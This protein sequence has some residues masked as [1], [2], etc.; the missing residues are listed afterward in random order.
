VGSRLQRAAATITG[1]MI[2]S[3]VLGIGIAAA[4]TTPTTVPTTTPITTATTPTTVAPTTVAPTTVPV[5]TTTAKEKSADKE[6]GDD[7]PWLEV[8][9]GAV[10]VGAIGAG[11]MALLG[12]RNRARRVVLDW[13]RRA[14]D[15][16]TEIGAT[17]RL[18]AAGT[19][20]SAAI[21]Q[22]VV[23]SL[24]ALDDLAQSAPDEMSR[25]TV[26]EARQ[27]VRALGIAI[28]ADVS[29]RRAQPP[30]PPGQLEAAAAGLRETAAE[31]D[32]T[33]RSTYHVFNPPS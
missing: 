27:A 19:P 7:F 18:L 3:L 21:A 5:T 20:V 2:T 23:A 1:G 8:L 4:Q 15:A 31:T 29:A 11:V 26:H 17:A 33:L 10:I 9:I 12:K 22:Q 13:R 30:L 6:S 24:R 14:A 16:T 32:R 28:D 25:T